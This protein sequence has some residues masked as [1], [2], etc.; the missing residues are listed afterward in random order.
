MT[1]KLGFMMPSNQAIV[2]SVPIAQAVLPWLHLDTEVLQTSLKDRVNDIEYKQVAM[3][4][5]S[6]EQWKIKNT[7]TCHLPDLTSSR[8]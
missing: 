6:H 3:S 8:C 2:T 7:A 4:P 1:E 5:T